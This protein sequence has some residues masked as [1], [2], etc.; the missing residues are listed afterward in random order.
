MA[1]KK[2]D[3]NRE[4]INEELEKVKEENSKKPGFLERFYW[5]LYWMFLMPPFV[6]CYILILPPFQC[7]NCH[8]EL[9]PDP[10]K[11]FDFRCPKCKKGFNHS[12]LTDSE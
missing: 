8:V 3:S 4:K 12:D 9:E 10:E 6:T 1:D 2:D 7:P 5:K 11:K